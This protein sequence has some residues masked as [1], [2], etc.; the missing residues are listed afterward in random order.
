MRAWMS[1]LFPRPTWGLPTRITTGC[2]TPGSSI[3]SAT[4]VTT[5]WRTRTAMALRTVPSTSPEPT[6]PLQPVLSWFFTSGRTY[7]VRYTDDLGSGTW[8]DLPDGPTFWTNWC[9]LID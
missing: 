3:T 2:R 8:Q 4:S 9:R 6:P 7:T 1:S 5:A